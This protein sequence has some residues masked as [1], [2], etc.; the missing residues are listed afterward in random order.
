MKHTVLSG[1]WTKLFSGAEM[2]ND[3]VLQSPFRVRV[4]TGE[5]STSLDP[6]DGVVLDRYDL[7]PL[8]AGVG[9]HVRPIEPENGKTVIVITIDD[10][11]SDT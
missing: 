6:N 9:V 2:V 11:V 3:K 8:R 7:Y 1:E 10:G 5:D 4:W